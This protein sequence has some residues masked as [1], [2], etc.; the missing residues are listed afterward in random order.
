MSRKILSTFS[1]GMD[2]SR[3]ATHEDRGK[4]KENRKGRDEKEG[5][6]G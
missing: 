1:L 6:T 3:D 5:L 4:S 2:D